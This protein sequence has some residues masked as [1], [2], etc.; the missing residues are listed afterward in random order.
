MY[1]PTSRSW[2][3]FEMLSMKMVVNSLSISVPISLNLW[4]TTDLVAFSFL[5]LVTLY[6]FTNTHKRARTHTNTHTHTHIYVTL[7]ENHTLPLSPSYTSNLSLS[8]PLLYTRTKQFHLHAHNHTYTNTHT[9][10]H[11]PTHTLRGEIKSSHSLQETRG[12][13]KPLPI[14]QLAIQEAEAAEGKGWVQGC[15]VGISHLQTNSTL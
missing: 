14:M 12:Q 7:S 9:H 15:G 6:C 2:K 10:T 3:R 11:T 8:Q 13:A 1:M 5:S 4:Y